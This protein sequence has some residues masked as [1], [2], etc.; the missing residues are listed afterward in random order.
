MHC[1]KSV[2]TAPARKHLIRPRTGRKIAGVALAFAEYFDL[3]VSL[4]RVIWLLVAIFGGTGIVAYL[5]CWIVIPS[6][7]EIQ[8]SEAQAA[9]TTSSPVGSSSITAT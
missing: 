8:T 4:I 7:P 5:V 9:A 6:E 3:D 2:G 1:N